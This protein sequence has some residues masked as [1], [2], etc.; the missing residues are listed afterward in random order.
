V[1]D[2]VIDSLFGAACFVPHGYRLGWRPDREG[3]RDLVT[4]AT[5]GVFLITA[6]QLWPLIAKGLKPPSPPALHEANAKSRRMLEEKGRALRQIHRLFDS[7][8]DPTVIMNR[9][10]ELLCGN[11]RMQRLFGYSSNAPAGQSV[12]LPP[13]R[14]RQHAQHRQDASRARIACAHGTAFRIS[15]ADLKHRKRA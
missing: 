15:V 12:E 1:V 8:P 3:F 14:H 10:G 9:G 2:Q 7:A 11:R 5:A 6:I 4:A 13:D